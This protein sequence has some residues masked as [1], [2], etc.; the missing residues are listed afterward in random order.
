MTCLALL[1]RVRVLFRCQ[2]PRVFPERTGSFGWVT[3][4]RS[5]S[6]AIFIFAAV[7][8]MSGVSS[9]SSS[10]S[11][12][13]ASAAESTQTHIKVKKKR[14]CV[15]HIDSIGRSKHPVQHYFRVTGDVDCRKRPLLQCIFCYHVCTHRIESQMR[16]LT[17]CEGCKTREHAVYIAAQIW[18]ADI[19]GVRRKRAQEREEKQQKEIEECVLCVC[20]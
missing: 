6:G 5:S 17:K 11:S 1:R 2:C 10:S 19:V 12:S 16:H 8:V 9:S 13:Q 18:L 3:W 14:V 15:T 7:Y 20:I 4:W